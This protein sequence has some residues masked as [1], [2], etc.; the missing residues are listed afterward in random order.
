MK[1]YHGEEGK[2]NKGTIQIVRGYEQLEMIAN[3]G[4]LALS[5][6]LGLTVM[7]RMF[8]ADATGLAG[9]KGKHNPGRAA[10]R[11]GNEKTSVVLGA[12]PR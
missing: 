8:E 9:T 3:E 11:H 12:E 1:A 10:C 2:G 5:V 7:K 4:L 6:E